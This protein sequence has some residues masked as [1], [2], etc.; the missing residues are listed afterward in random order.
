MLNKFDLTELSLDEMGAIEEYIAECMNDCYECGNYCGKCG[1]CKEG[2]WLGNNIDE[3][4]TKKRY[5]K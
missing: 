5:E 3:C 4:L 2:V 1:R